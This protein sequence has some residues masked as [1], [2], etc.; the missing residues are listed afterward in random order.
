MGIKDASVFTDWFIIFSFNINSNLSFKYNSHSIQAGR[1]RVRD[2]MR[3]I[4]IYLIL[5]AAL[6]PGVYSAS[7]RNERQKKKNHVSGD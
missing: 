4:S 1:S 3:I 6:G 5:S 2:P 7:I